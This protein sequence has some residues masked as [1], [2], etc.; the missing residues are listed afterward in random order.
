M[1]RLTMCPFIAMPEEMDK[2]IL[3]VIKL[4]PFQS[5]SSLHREEC[6]DGIEDVMV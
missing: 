6:G 2:M 1:E 3:F 4:P 5:P